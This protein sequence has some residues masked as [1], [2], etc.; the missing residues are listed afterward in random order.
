M[1][2]VTAVMEDG[3]GRADPAGDEGS[4]SGGGGGELGM[5]ARISKPAGDEANLDVA[6]SSLHMLT[7][8]LCCDTLIF[9]IL[10]IY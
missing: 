9:Q 5:L 1:L 3:G 6:R 8:S 7:W 4:D 2:Q 10:G